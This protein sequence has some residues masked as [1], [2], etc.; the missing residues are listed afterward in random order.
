MSKHVKKPKSFG[1]WGNT[2]KPRFWEL[3]NP[4]LDWSIEKG[5]TSFITTRIRDQLP[6]NFKYDVQVI[7]SA[8]DFIKLDFLLAL[9]GDG[10]M[11]SAAR[12]VG[13]RNTPILGIHLGELGFLAEVTSN[14]MFDRLNMV[15]SGNYGLQKRMVIEAE[16][17]NGEGPITFFALNDFVIDRGKSHRMITL[18]LKSNERFVADYKADG[19]I[20]G[21]PTGST[22]YSLS[23]GGPIIMPKLKAIVV[24]PISPHTLNLRPIVL[25]DDRILEISFPND[26]VDKIAF[27]VDGQVNEYLDPQAKI[28][29]QKATF[30]IQMIDFKDSNYFDILQRK[31][32]WGKRGET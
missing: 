5:L 17:N 27:A 22:A 7:E 2:D 26:G 3:L 23:A 14:E 30:D 9:G 18:R 15:E 31:M 11:L 6:S 8:E 21:T 13:N 16:I 19:L 20:I 32:G 24:V 4:I 28:S 25:P 10:T 1:I 29:I 12:A